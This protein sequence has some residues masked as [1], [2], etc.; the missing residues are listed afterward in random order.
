MGTTDTMRKNRAAKAA[1]VV[2]GQWHADFSTVKKYADAKGIPLLAVWSNGDAC[3]NCI[4]FEKC[5]LDS[6]FKSWAKTS[7]VAL[8]MGLNGDTSA[9][10]KF[11]GKGFHFARK[12]TLKH[13]PFVRLYWP[14]G[15]VDVAKRGKDW[16]GGTAKGAATLVKNLKAAL[17]AYKPSTAATVV[18]P[19]L[20]YAP[21]T[22]IEGKYG[23]TVDGKVATALDEA[24]AKAI[25]A[26]Y[27]KGAKA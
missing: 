16:S 18:L 8:W 12:D 14:K 15:K 19:K 6:K 20:G 1:P 9:E 2:E 11:E 23:L 13:Y 5:V 24:V 26:A 21:N 7:G 22:L 10:D 4:N 3:Q 27:D 17:K 25:I